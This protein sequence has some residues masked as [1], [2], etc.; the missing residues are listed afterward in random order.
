MPGQK[1]G[2]A[3]VGGYVIFRI[4]WFDRNQSQAPRRGDDTDFLER[5]EGIMKK[6]PSRAV[7]R[8]AQLSQDEFVGLWSIALWA[9]AAIYLLAT[10][11]IY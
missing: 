4:V 11:E 9:L 8:C 2:H 1:A 6:A 3:R 10:F 7:A 5:V